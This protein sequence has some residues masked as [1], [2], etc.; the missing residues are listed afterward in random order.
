VGGGDDAH[1]DLDRAVAAHALEFALLQHAQQLDLD[2]RAGCR[3]S[4]RENSVP[5]WASSKRPLRSAIAPVNAPFSWPNSSLSMIVLRQGGAVHLDER[6][7]RAVAVVVNRMGH[8]LLAGAGLA[9]I[10]TVVG[11]FDTCAIWS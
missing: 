1:V 4:R 3:R 6:L 2:R 10:S 11:L 5:P 9:Q 7:V 8:E